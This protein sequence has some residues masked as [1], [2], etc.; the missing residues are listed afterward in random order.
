LQIRVLYDVPF[1]IPM[2][3]AVAYISKKNQNPLLLTSIFLMVCSVSIRCLV[4]LYLI[5]P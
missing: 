5:K 1:Q 3:M 2:A 4:N